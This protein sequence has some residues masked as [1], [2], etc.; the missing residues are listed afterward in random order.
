LLQIQVRCNT[1]RKDIKCDGHFKLRIRRI[2]SLHLSFTIVSPLFPFLFYFD[3]ASLSRW[4]YKLRS[5]RMISRSLPF[6]LSSRHIGSCDPCRRRTSPF[7]LFFPGESE[8]WCGQRGE[9][10][11]NCSALLT[12]IQAA[13]FHACST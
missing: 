11:Q 6:S 4:R 13:L 3:S 8:R 7:C 1:P 12:K 10:Q 5:A 2:T 9:M